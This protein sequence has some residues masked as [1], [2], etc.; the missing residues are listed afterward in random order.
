MAWW[1]S[2]RRSRSEL[3]AGFDPSDLAEME[4][5]FAAVEAEQLQGQIVQ[6]APVLRRLVSRRVP[7]R[8]VE[9]APERQAIRVRFADGTQL[10]V[11]GTTPGDAG[12]LAR[13]LLDRTVLLVTWLEAEGEARLTF[14]SPQRRGR[15][16]F[17]VTGL[18]NRS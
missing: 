13:W 2:P 15:L 7:A 3:Q 17:V 9:P 16:G 1:S 14:A 5:V 10:L 8:A 4:A 18:D 6:A 11:R 12:V